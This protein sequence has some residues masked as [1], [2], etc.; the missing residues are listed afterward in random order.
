MKDYAILFILILAALLG[1]NK[2]KVI[3]P[4]EPK[5]YLSKIIEPKQGTT[6]YNYD[7]KNKIKTIVF[8]TAEEST[9]PSDI[10]QDFKFNANGG[11]LEYTRSYKISKRDPSKIINIYNKNGILERQNY[12]NTKT[13]LLANYSA[14]ENTPN[15]IKINYFDSNDKLK[16]YLEYKMTADGKNYTELSGYDAPKILNYTITNSDYDNYKSYAI[17]YPAGLFLGIANMNNEKTSN[18]KQGTYMSNS[19]FTYEYNEDG[20]VTKRIAAN[21]YTVT[22]EYLKLK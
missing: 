20:F 11:I 5:T 9:N 3:A 14:L 8:D 13:G 1:C 2:T 4:N 15:T 16:S 7:A 12:I 22:F 10:L 18:F 6:T 17:L 21:G 19:K